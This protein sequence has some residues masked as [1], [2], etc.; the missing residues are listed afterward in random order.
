MHMRG[1]PGTMQQKTDYKDILREVSDGLKKSVEKCLGTGI[2][3]DKIIIDPGIGFAKTA[4]QNLFLLRHLSRMA[5]LGCPVLTG[6]S[7]K[8]FI[9]KVLGQDVR[10][11][12]IGTIA[13]NV[14]AAVNGAHIIRAHDVREAVQALTMADAIMA[15]TV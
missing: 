6:I 13:A 2:T 15:A 12:L 5:S 11:R 14:L 10:H 1:T 3:R 7:R 8:S 4:E 9:G